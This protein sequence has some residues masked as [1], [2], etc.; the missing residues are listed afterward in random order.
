MNNNSTSAKINVAK[1]DQVFEHMAKSIEGKK[2]SLAT[3]IASQVLTEQI[4]K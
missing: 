3:K 1:F 2:P 4:M